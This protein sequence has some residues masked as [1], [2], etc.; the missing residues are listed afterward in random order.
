MAIILERIKSSAP[1]DAEA[2]ALHIESVGSEDAMMMLVREMVEAKQE[3]KAAE[4][5]TNATLQSWRP[6]MD[7]VSASIKKLAKEDERRNNL[8]EKKMALAERGAERDHEMEADRLKAVFVPLVTALA[9]AI[10]TAAA[11]HFGGG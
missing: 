6:I 2:L 3:S 4:D 9:G 1:S 7:S 8:D 5:K 10:T 11:Y